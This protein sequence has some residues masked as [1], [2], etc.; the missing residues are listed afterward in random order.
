MPCRSP[1]D[2]SR[3]RGSW[4]RRPVGR[5][6]L[7]LSSLVTAKQ[8]RRPKSSHSPPSQQ[9]HRYHAGA[10]ARP[11][12]SNHHIAETKERERRR[13]R[14]TPRAPADRRNRGRLVRAA[15]ASRAALAPGRPVR[16]LCRILTPR[17][18]RRKSAALRPWLARIHVRPRPRAAPD[19]AERPP[20]EKSAEGRRLDGGFRAPLRTNVGIRRRRVIGLTQDRAPGCA[21]DRGAQRATGCDLSATRRRCRPT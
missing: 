2:P 5:R 13:G 17:P 20:G 1:A 8:R 3:R 21:V 9:S 16:L 10:E 18:L 11:R 4:Q 7:R 19:A 6:F 12:L 14:G 15:G